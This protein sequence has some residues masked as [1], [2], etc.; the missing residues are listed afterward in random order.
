MKKI[1]SFISLI[2]FSLIIL[3]GISFF[4]S[5]L[6]G[7]TILQQESSTPQVLSSPESVI[8]EAR[9]E[10]VYFAEVLQNKETAA[11]YSITDE[12]EIANQI[13]IAKIAKKM[14]EERNFSLSEN[15]QTNFNNKEYITFLN[16]NENNI[17]EKLLNSKKI[18]CINWKYSNV[19]KNIQNNIDF[20]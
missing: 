1:I 4:I 8:L 9:G 18:T 11:K 17:K 19:D 6:I 10:K 2:V 13:L 12:H 16:L 3:L 15:S 5:K 20:L 14:L 7:P